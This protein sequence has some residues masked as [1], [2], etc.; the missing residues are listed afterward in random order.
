MKTDDVAGIVEYLSWSRPDVVVRV[1]LDLVVIEIRVDVTENLRL[2][3]R[4]EFDHVCAVITLNT[5][6]V[7]S[8]LLFHPTDGY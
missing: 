4:A 3:V 1:S 2:A 8:D 5:I 6:I 7:D